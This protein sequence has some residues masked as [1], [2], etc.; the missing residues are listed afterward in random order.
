MINMNYRSRELV[1]TV[2]FVCVGANVCTLLIQLPCYGYTLIRI[3]NV[4]L[5]YWKSR[6]VSFFQLGRME[7][8]GFSDRYSKRK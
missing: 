8:C 5:S 1:K 3:R 7:L 2:V 6:V 4:C